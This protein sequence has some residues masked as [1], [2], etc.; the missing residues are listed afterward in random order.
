[1]LS[2]AAENRIAPKLGTVARQRRMG[3]PGR[4]SRCRGVGMPM[5][6]VR[7][8]CHR[9]VET[10]QHTGR[11]RGPP[12]LSAR[13]GENRHLDGSADAVPF[14][15]RLSRVPSSQL[16]RTASGARFPRRSSQML[17]L[18]LSHF[19][20]DGHGVPN[21][22]NCCLMIP[23]VTGGKTPTDCKGDRTGHFITALLLCVPR[24]PREPPATGPALV[25]MVQT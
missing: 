8:C 22:V 6:G 14:A 18:M 1:M 15:M 5:V 13:R 21:F 2:T 4:V 16:T 9:R 11:T 17:Q 19:T 7:G 3:S 12:G 10:P 24:S 20:F 23:L 25:R